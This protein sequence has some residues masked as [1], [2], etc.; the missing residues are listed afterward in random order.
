M[1]R[2]LLCRYFGHRPETWGSLGRIGPPHH[3]GI[4]RAHRMV[5]AQCCR[6][7]QHFCVGA[8]IDK[9]QTRAPAVSIAMVNE[10]CEA[11]SDYLAFG[12]DTDNSEASKAA[13]RVYSAIEAIE[14]TEEMIHFKAFGVKS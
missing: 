6:C 11:S 9:T 1:I 5:Y 7:G 3:D 2:R 13:E 4:G 14:D 10:L 12:R 8:V